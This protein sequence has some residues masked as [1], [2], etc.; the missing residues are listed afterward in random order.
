MF[1]I[2]IHA[3]SSFFREKAH[4]ERICMGHSE[5]NKRVYPYVHDRNV[6]FSRIAFKMVLFKKAVT[7]VLFKIT[8]CVYLLPMNTVQIRLEIE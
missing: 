2:T 5:V 4:T 7:E 3:E 6:R 1:K 8:F